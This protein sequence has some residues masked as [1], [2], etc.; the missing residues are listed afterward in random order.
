[1][2][3]TSLQAQTT[4]IANNNPGASGGTNVFTGAAALTLATASA[5]DG[6]IIYVVPSGISYDDL[7][8]SFWGI[9]SDNNDVSD[10]T[11]YYF[12]QYENKKLPRF[13]VLSG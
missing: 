3:T 11:Y 2:L 10:G 4:W 5:S 13:F 9:D 7:E 6:D 1:M 12:I 8:R